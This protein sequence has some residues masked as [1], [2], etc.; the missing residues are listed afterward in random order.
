M[1]TKLERVKTCPFCQ[2][3]FQMSSESYGENILVV[4]DLNPVAPGHRLI[5][6]RDHYESLLE[7]STA[8]VSALFQVAVEVGRKVV[9]DGA[10]GFNLGVNNG[11]SAGQ[12]VRHL[13]IH[14]IPRAIGD[15]EDAF[16]GLRG[17]IPAKRRYDT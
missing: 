13:H 2:V 7:I 15:V 12:S 5:V 9:S 17:V 3:S 6:P 8:L 10:D 16:G 14:V 1:E 11:V 4:R